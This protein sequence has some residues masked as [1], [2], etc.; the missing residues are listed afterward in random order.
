MKKERKG[1][2]EKKKKRKK[3]REEEGRKEASK[4]ANFKKISTSQSVI[5][6]NIVENKNILKIYD[7]YGNHYR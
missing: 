3:E 5:Y 4:Q 1:G 2:E 6:E 7:M